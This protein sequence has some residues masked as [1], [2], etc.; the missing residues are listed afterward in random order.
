MVTTWKIPIPGSFE[1]RFV[2]PFLVCFGISIGAGFG[3]R[4]HMR[5]CCAGT[6]GARSYVFIPWVV[7]FTLVAWTVIEIML[8]YQRLG[9]LAR[10][11]AQFHGAHDAIYASLMTPQIA[12]FSVLTFQTNSYA[13]ITLHQAQC[14]Q[15][16][17]LALFAALVLALWQATHIPGD[18]KEADQAAEIVRSILTGGV[19]GI[20]EAGN[21]FNIIKAN[22]IVNNF[23]NRTRRDATDF[24]CA[25]LVVMSVRAGMMAD[26]CTS[27]T[28]Y[29]PLPTE[30]ATPPTPPVQMLTNG[31]GLVGKMSSLSNTVREFFAIDEGQRIWPWVSLPVMIMGILYPILIPPIFYSVMGDDI[32]YIGPVLSIFI[33]GAV[34]FNVCMADPIKNPNSFHF[35]PILDRIHAMAEAANNMFANTF[36]KS[37]TVLSKRDVNTDIFS[38]LDSRL[39]REFMLNAYS[40]ATTRRH[41][42]GVD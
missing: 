26:M 5:S 7:A 28:H 29:Y 18:S 34:L 36:P 22:I 13:I 8:K 27:A 30:K 4:E 23:I 19:D 37:D 25:L 15:E 42:R 10:V 2:V 35:Q 33:T 11:V 12:A 41:G 24:A 16:M 6:V 38:Q 20:S 31:F 14:V 17:V 1:L 21:G 9:A 32:V 3:W 40:R 39:D